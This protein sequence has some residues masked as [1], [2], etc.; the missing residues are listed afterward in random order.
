M[1]KAARGH[2]ARNRRALRKSAT[3]ATMHVNTTGLFPGEQAIKAPDGKRTAKDQPC[4][5]CG[6]SVHNWFAGNPRDPGDVDPRA[7]CTNP[8]CGW[9]Y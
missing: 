3:A 5:D 9:G 6:W 7:D 8:D 1:P 2:H 4:P